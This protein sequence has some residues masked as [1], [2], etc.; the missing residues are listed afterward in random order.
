MTFPLF[1]N[2]GRY[3][4]LD[5]FNPLNHLLFINIDGLL[6]VGVLWFLSSLFFVGIIYCLIDK[7]NKINQNLIVLM[8]MIIGLSMP[9]FIRLP[10]ALDTAFVGIGLYH[11]GY[12]LKNIIIKQ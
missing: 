9:R 1:I 12:L 4:S 10:C 7:Q 3:T 2:I 5:L 8:I 6:I 11:I